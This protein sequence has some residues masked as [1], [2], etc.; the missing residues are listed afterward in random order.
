MFLN[1]LVLLNLFLYKNNYL[2]P[3]SHNEIF[4]K[5]R[6]IKGWLHK[7]SDQFIHTKLQK[8]R[9]FFSLLRISKD[10]K[11]SKIWNLHGSQYNDLPPL[12]HI[13]LL[14]WKISPSFIIINI[15]ISSF[16]NL[17]LHLKTVKLLWKIN[18]GY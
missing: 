6:I 10:F 8:Q 18:I 14:S 17:C 4:I 3:F 9:N 2:Y 12:N 15:F 7:S 13:L 16:C 5:E 1:K 11:N